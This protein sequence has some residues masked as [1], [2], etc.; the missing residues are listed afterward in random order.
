M[1]V[2]FPKP[3]RLVKASVQRDATPGKATAPENSLFGN[4]SDKIEAG[5]QKKCNLRATPVD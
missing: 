3:G 5:K 4:D 2:K 1:N